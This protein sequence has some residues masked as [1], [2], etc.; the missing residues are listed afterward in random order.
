MRLIVSEFSCFFPPWTVA[1]LIRSYLVKQ[2]VV[3][4]WRNYGY[5]PVAQKNKKKKENKT[6]KTPK[7]RRL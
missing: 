1:Q 6:K 2:S 4:A 7:L 5:F 3:V